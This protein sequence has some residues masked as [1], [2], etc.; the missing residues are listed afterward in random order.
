M[1]LFKSG[2]VRIRFITGIIRVLGAGITFVTELL[3][4]KKRYWHINGCR[5]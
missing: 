4:K 2:S 5:H 3:Q 1:V